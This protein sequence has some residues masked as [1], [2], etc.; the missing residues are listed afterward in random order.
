MT[1]NCKPQSAEIPVILHV[2]E[3]TFSVTPENIDL[4]I[5]ASGEK[6]VNFSI[7]NGKCAVDLTV[8]SSNEFTEGK[9]FGAIFQK[10]VSLSP[11]Q[12]VTFPVTVK[13]D[14]LEGNATIQMFFD[15]PYGS[16]SEITPIHTAMTS[17]NLILLKV[18]EG[19]ITEVKEPTYFKIT[20]TSETSGTTTM[21][22]LMRE[23]DK[24]KYTVGEYVKV[25]GTIGESEN[26][27]IP[28]EIIPI[29]EKCNYRII[30]P[31]ELIFCPWCPDKEKITKAWV[32]NTGKVDIGVSISWN[33]FY[34]PFTIS[35]NPQSFTLAPGE[36]KEV[37]V[38]VKFKNPEELSN[39]YFE[40]DKYPV[41]TKFL[42]TCFTD[43]V[44]TSTHMETM[45]VEV[46]DRRR[47]I[48]GKVTFRNPA[49][50]KC[51]VKGAKVFLLIK[52]EVEGL[53]T[54]CP[55]F[56]LKEEE[57]IN[58]INVE[59]SFYDS[60]PRN[61]VY[62]TK[63]YTKNDGSFKFEEF[64]DPLCKHNY[65]VIVVFQSP[66][67]FGPNL[68][69]CNNCEKTFFVRK[70]INKTTFPCSP[71]SSGVNIYIG[72]PGDPKYDPSLKIPK[73]FSSSNGKATGVDMAQIW[74]H[75]MES[76]GLFK[77]FYCDSKGALKSAKLKVCA[78]SKEGGTWYYDKKININKSDSFINSKNRPMN[79]EWHEFGHYLHDCLYG[80]PKRSVSDENH[81]NIKNSNT[82]D[83]FIEGFAEFISMLTL[84]LLKDKGTCCDDLSKFPNGN[85][86]GWGNLENNGNRPIGALQIMY[87]G[88]TV[89]VKHD[90]NG[91]PYIKLN[92]REI[93]PVYFSKNRDGSFNVKF[94]DGGPHSI[95][96]AM[97]NSDEELS[98]ASVLLDLVDKGSWYKRGR[99]DDGLSIDWKE[100]LCF[101]KEKKI[102]DMR[103]LYEKLREKYDPSKIDDIFKKNGFFQDKNLN[104]RRDAGE[105]IG[106]TYRPKIRIDGE[107]V[108]KIEK[109][110]DFPFPKNAYV[111]VN[112][113]DKE[114]RE[115]D[116]ADVLIEFKTLDGEVSVVE[117]KIKNGK[118][119]PILIPPDSNR[120]VVINIKG[121]KGKPIIITED[122]FW[123]ALLNDKPYI[124]EGTLVKTEEE[125]SPE[126]LLET[127]ELYLED[128]LEGEKETFYI[129]F[130]NYGGGTLSINASTTNSWISIEPESFEGNAGFIKITVNTEGLSG[131]YHEGKVLVSGNGGEK[132]IK[133]TL[134]I[135]STAK[136]TVIE[137]FI[138]KPVAYINGETYTLDVA[139]YI[140]LPGR[141]MVPLRFISE[142]LGA[143]VD[144]AP[145]KGKVKEVYI[146]FK[147]KNVTLYIGKNEALI[148]NE[149]VYLDAPPE[150]KPPGRT[151]VP[152]R[153]IA[154]TFGADVEWDPVLRKVTITLE[155]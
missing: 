90:K 150:I 86:H 45:F 133:A 106:Y 140:K 131:G 125:S 21:I 116:E 56:L 19:E 111:I 101:M 63:T 6:T 66:D 98:A 4:K 113:M 102:Q 78:F 97:K 80:I 67:S 62:Y 134:S 130:I 71:T 36:G 25:I 31:G 87:K 129:P 154:E 1:S 64:L 88:N 135:I 92:K 73:D 89:E 122:E 120:F 137:L 110:R 138:G 149:K 44:T 43:P 123:N 139:P 8:S 103:D 75:V 91:V 5:E 29:E 16:T 37:E 121:S 93:K 61:P 50:K 105:E 20:E 94:N 3:P 107:E 99:D 143:T 108:D 46:C 47:D 22:I 82:T 34:D 119:I 104:R 112:L 39:T 30:G 100:L 84:K 77:D 127:K 12:G 40:Q 146:F 28:E 17:I 148:D 68:T 76:Y 155:E 81:G 153:F 26:E 95:P 10:N 32:E 15:S 69:Y 57:K 42:I 48:S 59:N 2:L 41:Y 142:G 14:K 152:I 58:S 85:Y 118:K 9:S 114:G 126:L 147:G 52:D 27:I 35:F 151:F 53:E 145:K 74:C 23:E 70:D 11:Y 24:G 38:K 144:Y 72:N 13:T 141:T 54:F 65:A 117:R 136:K 132:E 33:E 49:G 51:P 96:L 79:R 18:V 124:K 83:S 115:I 7:Q 55:G 109:R 60:I 128:I